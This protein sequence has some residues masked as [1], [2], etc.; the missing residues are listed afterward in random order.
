MKR[1]NFYFPK[2]ELKNP[3]TAKRIKK[4]FPCHEVIIKRIES[5]WPVNT[6]NIDLSH[7]LDVERANRKVFKSPGLLQVVSRGVKT[8]LK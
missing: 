6:S 3:K 2:N 8:P 7:T 4:E 5:G 1:L